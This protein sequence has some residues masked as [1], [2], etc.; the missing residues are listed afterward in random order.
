GDTTVG[1]YS[2]QSRDQ[3][4]KAKLEK[5]ARRSQP[6]VSM[7]YHGN[8]FRTEELVPALFR[9]ETGIYESFVMSDRQM[10]DKTVVTAL[11]RLI[12]QMRQ[13]P[14]PALPGGEGVD[15]ADETDL[16]LFNIHRNWQS[17][18]DDP[19]PPTRDELIGVLRTILGSI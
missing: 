3:K 16:I 17:L 11:E 8:K 5:R 19:R 12:T 18:A 9:T 10:T 14:L 4:R 1:K 13:G 7:A 2:R 15:L 6:H